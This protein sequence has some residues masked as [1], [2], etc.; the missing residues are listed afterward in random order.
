MKLLFISHD[1]TRTGAPILLLNLAKLIL[2]KNPDSITFLLK[3]SGELENEFKKLGSV[4]HVSKNRKR[5]VDLVRNRKNIIKDSNF[6]NQFDFIISNTITNG[7]ILKIIRENYNGK[8]ISYIHELEIATKTYTNSINVENT[9]KSSDSFWVPSQIVNNFIVNTYNI[10]QYKVS[11]MPYYIENNSIQKR[12]KNPLESKTFV[13]GGCG[14]IDW[15]KGPD[16]FIIVAKRVIEKFPNSSVKFKWIGANDGIE[17]ER[18]NYELKKMNIL[19]KV[20]FEKS[21]SD[22][23]NFYNSIDL[24][25]L[26]SREDPYPLVI[27]EAANFEVPSICFDNVCGSVDFISDSDGGNIVPFLDLESMSNS[28]LHYINNIEFKQKKGLNA[29]NYF[30]KTHSDQ[31]YIFEKFSQLLLKCH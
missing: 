25:L 4:F 2:K 15:R 27:L 28:I 31:D 22:L 26:T 29:R 19:N 13:I 8:I 12:E 1:A 21:T 18:L 7:D 9:L 10:S 6:L 24:F 3:N 11:I 5:I 30:L 14:T 20:T 16:L 17:L 23:Y